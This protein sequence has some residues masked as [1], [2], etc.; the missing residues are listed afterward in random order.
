MVTFYR[1]Q[2]KSTQNAS[3][4]VYEYVQYSTADA[5]KKQSSYILMSNVEV[6]H[7]IGST[8]VCRISFFF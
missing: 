2:V 5:N 1:K 4:L 3:E 8:A 7:L 6:G